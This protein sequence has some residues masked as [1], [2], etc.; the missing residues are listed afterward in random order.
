M[1]SSTACMVLDSRLATQRLAYWSRFFRKLSKRWIKPTDTEHTWMMTIRPREIVESESELRRSHQIVSDRAQ[2]LTIFGKNHFNEPFYSCPCARDLRALNLGLASI[3]SHEERSHDLHW[4][5]ALRIFSIYSKK[6]GVERKK[7]KK[8]SLGR[9]FSFRWNLPQLSVHM[10]VVFSSWIFEI[11]LVVYSDLFLAMYRKASKIS[12]NLA[13]FVLCGRTMRWNG[14]EISLL[15]IS[16]V[17]HGWA[18]RKSHRTGF[19]YSIYT[20]KKTNIFENRI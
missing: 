5:A 15:Y 14:D 19:I 2:V 16:S 10:C 6:R 12:L 11:W 8:I 17:V 4:V 13:L 7:R 9:E 20:N 18:C 3:D 1:L